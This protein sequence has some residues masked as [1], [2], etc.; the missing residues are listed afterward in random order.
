[1]NDHM[2]IS[3]KHIKKPEKRTSNKNN[4]SVVS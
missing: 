4:K 1:M 3:I 2:M